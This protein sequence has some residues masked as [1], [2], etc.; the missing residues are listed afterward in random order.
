MPQGLSLGWVSD[1]VAFLC[2]VW[3]ACPIRANSGVLGG[4]GVWVQAGEVFL[5]LT[6]SLQFTL[7]VELATPNPKPKLAVGIQ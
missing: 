2:N 1:K 5:D 6:A 7:E 3:I 4:M